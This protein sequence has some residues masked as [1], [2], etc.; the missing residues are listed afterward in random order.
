MGGTMTF[1]RF[2][3]TFGD[4]LIGFAWC[5][6]WPILSPAEGRAGAVGR[7]LLDRTFGV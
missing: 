1:L 3:R 6:E 5:S 7:S 2:W 4:E